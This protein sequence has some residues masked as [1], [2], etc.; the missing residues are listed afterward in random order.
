[1]EQNASQGEDGRGPVSSGSRL[2]LAAIPGATPD[3]WAHRWRQRHPEL[4][5]EVSYYDDAGQLERVREGTADVGYV[6]VLSDDG[7]GVDGHGGTLREAPQQ[8]EALLARE[9]RAAVDAAELHRV[10]LYREEPVVCAARDHWVAAAEESVGWE[11]IAEEPFLR[12]EE[13]LQ[14]W[15]GDAAGDAD[16]ETCA[17]SSL[18]DAAGGWRDQD[19]APSETGGEGP[20]AESSRAVSTPA[21]VHIPRAG[22][23]LARAERVAMEVAA[24]GAGLLILPNSV[25]RMLGRRDVVIRRVEG[26][27]GYDVGLAWRRDCDDAVIQEFVG[28]ARGRRPGSGRTELPEGSAGVDSGPGKGSGKSGRAGRRS[29]GTQGRR[30]R[31]GPSRRRPR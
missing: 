18:Q 8:A 13:M 11:E 21:S 20:L 7:A 27:P 4:D 16:G 5:L 26:L 23:D 29:G 30:R 2:R 3:K 25:A 17:A 9:L 22:A 19:H 28:I 6:R 24:S 12:P 14:G 31:P 10:V 15:S 1:M